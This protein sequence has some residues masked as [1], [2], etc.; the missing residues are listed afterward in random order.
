[1]KQYL[2]TKKSGVPWAEII[3]ESWDVIRGKN[4]LTLHIL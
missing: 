1:M 4:I 3:P 2:I